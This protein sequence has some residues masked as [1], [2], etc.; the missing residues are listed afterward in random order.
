MPW[1]ENGSIR[2]RTIPVALKGMGPRLRKQRQFGST[3][4]VSGMLLQADQRQLVFCAH[5]GREAGAV[6]PIRNGGCGTEPRDAIEAVNA[7]Q[8]DRDG[9][10]PP[11]PV[12]F[13]EWVWPCPLSG[14]GGAQQFSPHSL[15]ASKT[16]AC[17]GRGFAGLEEC[18][19][20]IRPAGRRPSSSPAS[21]RRDRSCPGSAGRRSRW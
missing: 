4:A 13:R 11:F 18:A 3:S 14:A 15:P 12:G 6:E 9:H 2:A 10:T 19:A 21:D 17:K 1:V 7:A 8:L 5:Q 20:S 16:P